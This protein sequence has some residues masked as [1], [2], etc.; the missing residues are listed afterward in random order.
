LPITVTEDIKIRVMAGDR[1]YAITYPAFSNIPGLD[2]YIVYDYQSSL[3]N[4]ITPDQAEIGGKVHVREG[5]KIAVSYNKSVGYNIVIK[6]DGIAY[7]PDAP[8]TIT[9]DGTLE[10]VALP[11]GYK[12]TVEALPQN[13]VNSYIVKRIKSPIG[14]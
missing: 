4:Y 8:I 6:Y 14:L 9:K 13:G 1:L 5:T 3:I 2:D 11:I 12:L 10:L 7:E